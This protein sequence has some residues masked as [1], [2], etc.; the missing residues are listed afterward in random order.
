MKFTSKSLVLA[1]SLA[2]LTSAGNIQASD[3]FS[4][5]QYNLNNP[6]ALEDDRYIETEMEVTPLNGSLS[7][8]P[9]LISVIWRGTTLKTGNVDS[10]KVTA[11][12]NGSS[13]NTRNANMSV[14]VKQESD[15][16]HGGTNIWD[17]S[18]L[19]LNFT[20]LLNNKY[21]KIEITVK[22]G[23]VTSTDGK[24][25]REFKLTYYQYQIDGYMKFIP[26]GGLFEEGTGEIRMQWPNASKAT[27]NMETPFPAFVDYM[28]LEGAVEKKTPIRDLMKEDG[29][30]IVLD[31]TS[32]SPGSY[33]LTLPEGCILLE[34]NGKTMM[35]GENYCDFIIDPAP[36]YPDEEEGDNPGNEDDPDDGDDDDNGSDDNGG[37]DNGSD[38]NG[39]DDN[40]SD[41]NGGDDNGSDD[42]GGD[43]NGSDDNRGD[44]NGSDDNGNDTDGVSSVIVDVDGLFKVFDLTGKPIL[45]TR[46]RTQLDALAPGL[47]IINGK[48]IV[49]Q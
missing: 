15:E 18:V 41:D 16:Q 23:A 2:I 47:Y 48:K 5:D 35:N 42:N 36:K 19:D 46:E 21:G 1:I 9:G 34:E 12:L 32:L 20:S 22:E 3:S 33:S 27:I 39:G 13:L 43:D 28:N 40:G 10:S 24:I 49:K 14:T 38:D 37:D 6:V 11:T 31:L 7:M 30:D 44:D 45:T 8:Y 25:N 29:G 17:V 4:S 26:Y